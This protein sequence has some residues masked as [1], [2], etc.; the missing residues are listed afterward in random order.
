MLDRLN[1]MYSTVHVYKYSN[2]Y[3]VEYFRQIC[4]LLIAVRAVAAGHKMV[5]EAH[6]T[7]ADGWPLFEEASQETG[8]GDLPQLLRSLKGMS[9]P[10]QTPNLMAT[11]T[12]SPANLPGS[13]GPSQI[14]SPS[15]VKFKTEPANPEEPIVIRVEGK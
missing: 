4:L 15:P 3:Y 8:P 6:K 7:I 13:K 14:P 2:T 12:T 11:S 10:T 5:S 9:T 1:R